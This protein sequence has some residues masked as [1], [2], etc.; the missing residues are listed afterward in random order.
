MQ[1]RGLFSTFGVMHLETLQKKSPRMDSYF[2]KTGQMRQSGDTYF[3]NRSLFPQKGLKKWN[4]DPAL[5]ISEI[6][7][8]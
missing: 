2:P 8:P 5:E 7:S 3:Q 1:N 4:M 6:I